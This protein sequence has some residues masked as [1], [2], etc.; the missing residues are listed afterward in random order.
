MTISQ[1]VIKK[2][3]KLNAT[4]KEYCSYYDK[5]KECC[6]QYKNLTFQPYECPIFLFIEIGKE[7]DERRMKRKMKMLK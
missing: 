6:S 1:H 7:S 3:K 4:C 2:Y 5:E